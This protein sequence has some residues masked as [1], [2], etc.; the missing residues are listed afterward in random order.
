MQD[1]GNRYTAQLMTA[2]NATHGVATDHPTSAAASRSCCSDPALCVAATPH[3]PFPLPP[4]PPSAPQHM[5]PNFNECWWDSW[6]L[7]V[8]LCNAAG[9]APGCVK[10]AEGLGSGQMDWGGGAR[11]GLILP[12]CMP[13]TAAHL[14]LQHTCPDEQHWFA[15]R[16]ESPWCA[17]AAG[18]WLGMKTVKYFECKYERYDWQGV[19]QLPSLQQKVRACL[20][21]AQRSPPPPPTPPTP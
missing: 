10:G 4:G 7:D 15:H 12:S 19:S 5:L 6:I 21:P 16:F 8:A 2:R 9:E 13:L 18:I 14:E 11:E 3:P 20:V 17:C 1:Q